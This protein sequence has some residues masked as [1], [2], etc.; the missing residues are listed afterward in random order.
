MSQ[1]GG[2]EK[3]ISNAEFK[4]SY[5]EFKPTSIGNI[6]IILSIHWAPENFNYFPNIEPWYHN[7]FRNMIASANELGVGT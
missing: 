1:K 5:A 6:T 3:Q 7:Y 4:A 2:R